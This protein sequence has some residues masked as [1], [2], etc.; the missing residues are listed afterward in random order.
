[1]GR[2]IGLD[3]G[4]KRIGIALADPLGI[5]AQPFRTITGTSERDKIKQISSMVQDL[6]VQKI[7]IGFPLTLRGSKGKSAKRVEE[8][9]KKLSCKVSAV[10]VYW[11]ERFT[12]VQARRV[13]HQMNK[14]A[15]RQKEKVDLIASVILLQSY[16]DHCKGSSRMYGGEGT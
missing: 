5:T 16:L 12:S 6:N 9:A 4:E 7:V 14:K 3:Y 10:I 8:F 11:D 15:S 13:L 2:I 1:M